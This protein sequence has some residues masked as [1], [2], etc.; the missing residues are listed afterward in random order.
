ML[1]GPQTRTLAKQRKNIRNVKDRAFVCA[2]DI[3]LLSHLHQSRWNWATITCVTLTDRLIV[4]DE[5]GSWSE[6][7]CPNCFLSQA[8][9]TSS[10]SSYINW[11]VVSTLSACAIKSNQKLFILWDVTHC[12]CFYMLVAPCLDSVHWTLTTF[13]P[14]NIEDCRTKAVYKY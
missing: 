7:V 12:G 13:W 1:L 4:V 10:C 8:M 5:V 11:A 3:H 2:Y 14:I 6:C 9:L